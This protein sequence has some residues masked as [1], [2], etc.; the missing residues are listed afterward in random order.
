VR[1]REHLED[2]LL[3]GRTILNGSS[4][5]GMDRHGLDCSGLG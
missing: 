5:S 2:L 1:K 3:D 4:V